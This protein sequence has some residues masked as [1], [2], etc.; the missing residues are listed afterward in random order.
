MLRGQRHDNLCQ[1]EGKGEK[2]SIG[3][4]PFFVLFS[5]YCGLSVWSL[6][7]GLAVR[8]M[9]DRS[10][11]MDLQC[12][13]VRSDHP[14]A[15]TLHCPIP[16]LY[17]LSVLD[18]DCQWLPGDSINRRVPSEDQGQEPGLDHAPLQVGTPRPALSPLSSSSSSSSCLALVSR[19]RLT[20]TTA[21]CIYLLHTTTMRSVRRPA[22]C[23][24][25][26]L[27]AWIMPLPAS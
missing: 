11:L 19:P 4:N 10:M 24:V 12:V 3:I 16:Y 22:P 17:T 14:H 21:H 18:F 20:P 27:P 8:T 2:E 26:T 23:L 13:M 15:D 1:W 7:H 5:L 6:V 25:G 9:T